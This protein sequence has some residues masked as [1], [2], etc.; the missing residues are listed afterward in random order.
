MS[1]RAILILCS[2]SLVGII[3]C[4]TLY[5]FA[6]SSPVVCVNARFFHIV[7]HSASGHCFSARIGVDGVIAIAR[8]D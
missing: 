2:L 1:V 4:M 7:F 5:Q 6:L 8:A 3:S